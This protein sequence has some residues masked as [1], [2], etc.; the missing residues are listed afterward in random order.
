MNPQVQGLDKLLGTYVFDLRV[1][2]RALQ[3]N[4]FFWYMIRA[5]WRERYQAD[6]EG[7]MNESG[8]TEYEKE[9]T[10]SHDWLGLVQ[11]GVNFFVLD[12]FI[13]VAQ[14]TN[15]QVY[16]IMR[17]ETLEEFLATRRVPHLR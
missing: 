17:G 5:D 4:R 7:L 2:N 8:L 9:L 16:A 6:P 10:R 15:P 12:K 13:R 14:M 3:I 1:S 11:H